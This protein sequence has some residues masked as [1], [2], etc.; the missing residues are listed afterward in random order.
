MT[1]AITIT[2]IAATVG[3]A[4]IAAA[5]LGLPPGTLPFAVTWPRLLGSVWL[6]LLAAIVGSAFSLRTVLRIDPAQAI[7]GN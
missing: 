1:Q 5:A 4:M 6:L 2:A 3:L 7:G